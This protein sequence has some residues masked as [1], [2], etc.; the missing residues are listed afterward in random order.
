MAKGNDKK[1]VRQ[2]R[3][4]LLAMLGNLLESHRERKFKGSRDQFC[5]SNNLKQSTVAFIETGRFL[6]LDLAQLCR[7]LAV[8]YARS[9]TKFITSVKKVYDGLKEMDNLMRVL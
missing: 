7:Y 8:T 5:Q 3:E 1:V 4:L 6:A 9:D 2:T